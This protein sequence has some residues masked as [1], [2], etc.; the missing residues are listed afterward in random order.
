MRIAWVVLFAAC[1]HAGGSGFRVFY[2]TDTALAK[3]H[4]QVRPSADCKYEDGRDARWSVTGA[5]VESGELPPGL[6]LEDAAING[7]PTTGGTF[8]AH[9]VLTGVECAGKELPD[10][11]VDVKITVL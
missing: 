7:T 10:Q 2:A 3:T 9:L 11:H 8:T 4:Y 6:A 1:A 5:R